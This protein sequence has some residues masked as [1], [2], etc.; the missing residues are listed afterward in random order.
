M[1]PDA[2]QRMFLE[3]PDFNPEVIERVYPNA[4]R[5]L[6]GGVFVSHSGLDYLRVREQIVFPV[7]AP[8]FGNA[9]FLHNRGTGAAESYRDIIQAALCYCDYFL[10]TVSQNSVINAWVRAEV[11]WATSRRRPIVA[12]LLD[13]TSP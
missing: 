3:H 11:W 2:I 5:V 10:L 12:C 9:L 13:E 6:K 7:V 4:R 1:A 8:R